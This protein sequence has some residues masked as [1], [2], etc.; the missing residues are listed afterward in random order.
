MS[1]RAVLVGLPGAGKSTTGRRLATMLGVPF[2]DSDSLVEAAAGSTVREIFAVQGEAVFREFERAAISQAL[3]DFDGVLSLGGGAIVTAQTRAALAASGV[4]IVLL[5]TSI[6]TLT[7]RVG[8][9]VS[10][11]LLADDPRDRL[12]ALARERE[13][14]YREL[15]THVVDTDRCSSARVAATIAGLLRSP[16]GRPRK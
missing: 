12:V 5:R 3:S 8:D 6:R 7:R 10:R 15:A 1:P 9:G 16:V 2:A 11:P 14:L 4:P 13:P